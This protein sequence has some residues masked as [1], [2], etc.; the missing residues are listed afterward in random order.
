MSTMC[1]GGGERE[2]ERERLRRRTV[3]HRGCPLYFSD[4]Q[5]TRRT[6][7]VPF[8]PGD[9]HNRRHRGAPSQLG[10]L[11]LAPAPRGPLAPLIGLDEVADLFEVDR[12]PGPGGGRRASADLAVG[13]GAP[14]CAP[15]PSNQPTRACACSGMRVLGRS[16]RAHVGQHRVAIN[17]PSSQPLWTCAR[18][19]VAVGKPARPL[20]SHAPTPANI[21][22][23]LSR[24]SFAPAMSLMSVLTAPPRA[25]PQSLRCVLCPKDTRSC[26]AA[27]RPS[28]LLDAPCSFV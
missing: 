9:H 11:A 28:T 16:S 24:A 22:F 25:A 4:V 26:C 14:Q 3:L 8:Q 6:R 12:T 7:A 10:L 13:K 17:Q 20:E 18:V 27:N 2:R 23:A 19:D 15:K 21:P 5:V 1:E